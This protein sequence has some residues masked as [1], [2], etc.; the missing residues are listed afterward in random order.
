M[1]DFGDVGENAANL[2]DKYSAADQLWTSEPC[3][4]IPQPSNCATKFELRRST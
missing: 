2:R 4:G 3:L 1:V